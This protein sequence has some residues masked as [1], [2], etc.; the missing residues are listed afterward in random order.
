MAGGLDEMIFE[1]S[2]QPKPSY[3]S[4]ILI[5]NVGF[6]RSFFKVTWSTWFDMQTVLL[7]AS[8]IKILNKSK[9]TL[10]WPTWGKKALWTAIPLISLTNKELSW[11]STGVRVTY[12]TISHS[13]SLWSIFVSTS[14]ESSLQD[15]LYCCFLP[16]NARR[17]SQHLPGRCSPPAAPA[18][19]K[20]AKPGAWFKRFK[21]LPSHE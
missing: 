20:P 11:F 16:C 9:A 12:I 8:G 18:K 6:L 10:Q 2:F 3:E 7:N 1:A 15:L 19:T 14:P 17:Q 5:F 13:L 4:M 21:L